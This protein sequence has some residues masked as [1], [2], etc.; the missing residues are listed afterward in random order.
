MPLTWDF[1]RQLEPSATPGNTTSFFDEMCQSLYIDDGYIRTQIAVLE[2]GQWQDIAREDEITIS[3]AGYGQLDIEHHFNGSLYG[4]AQHSSDVVFLL[5]EYMI[6]ITNWLEEGQWQL[7]PDNPIKTGLANILNGD[8]KKFENSAFTL[9]APGNV[10]NYQFR[11]GDSDPYDLAKFMIETSP[12]SD[13]AESFTFRGRNAIGFYLAGL[14]FDEA[15]SFSGTRT[16]IVQAML[17]AAGVPANM[18]L[19][20]TSAVTTTF[21]AED[22]DTYFDGLLAFVE[23]N[24]WYV[25]DKPDGT[26]VVG[27]ETFL[28]DNVASTGIHSFVREQEVFSRKVDRDM[29]G[30]YS[31]VCVRRKTDPV[32]RVFGDVPYFDG[33]NL[34]GNRTFYQ[35]VPETTTQGEMEAVRDQ[36][37]EGL[38][39]MGI[40]ETFSSP[41][42]PWLQPGDVCTITGDGARIVGIITDV[43]HRFGRRGFYTEFTVTSGGTISNPDNPVTVAT[44]YRGK[45]GGANRKRRMLDFLLARDNT[46]KGDKGD[47]GPAGEDSVVPGPPGDPGLPGEPG[48]DGVGVATGGTAGQV[49][50][51]IDG[52]DFNTEWVDPT[53][54]S[55]D[56]VGPAAGVVDNEIALFNSTTGKLIKGS[57]HTLA[58]YAAASHNHDSAYAAASHNHDSA[59]AAKALSG[60][61]RL[62][63]TAQ[64]GL[65]NNTSVKLTFDSTDYE[66]GTWWNTTSL[67]FII[68]AGVSH[69][70]IIA[71]ASI[72]GDSGSQW[73]LALQVY[74]NGAA[75][76][77]ARHAHNTNDQESYYPFSA[78]D[79][80]VV[81]GDYFELYAWAYNSGTATWKITSGMFSIRKLD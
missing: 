18:S 60:A 27:S 44:R 68:P 49:L 16:A 59:Y 22:E 48:A 21:E 2:S 43:Q 19:I 71:Q 81:E 45:L 9:F 66:V 77:S 20:E 31:R 61:K 62:K 3:A 32:L 78:E 75:V 79:F 33:W 37:I 5:Y 23:R 7:Q 52:T 24:N 73:A 67:R 28:K 11:A 53:A 72:L 38:Q 69:V 56:V 8:Y 41:F 1:A 30:V 12:Y 80:A 26:I 76:R 46:S 25:D 63:T 50:A 15:V 47:P 36:L 57:S 6:D 65:T 55:G 54:G 35:D 58:D 51:K 42:R 34:A 10:I 40:V 64:T 70:Q 39:Y 74:K 29:S 17:D 13:I 14:T 4:S